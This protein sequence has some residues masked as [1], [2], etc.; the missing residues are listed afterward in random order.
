MKLSNY[1]VYE[2]S[3]S[4]AQKSKKIVDTIISRL[5]K[6]LEKK[7]FVI[8]IG[9][10]VNLMNRVSPRNIKFIATARPESAGRYLSYAIFDW[11]NN[12][13]TFDINSKTVDYLR[14]FAKEHK[15]NQFFD[16]KKNQFYKEL[17]EL[18]SH[19]MAHVLQLSKGSLDAFIDKSDEELGSYLSRKWEIDAFSL[20]AALEI[21][22]GDRSKTWDVY[23]SFK[24][25]GEITDKVYNRFKKK[26]YR[27]IKDLQKMGMTK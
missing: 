25:S 21:I 4:A 6:G 16:A 3:A 8:S 24:A 9:D 20:Q 23:T 7:S 14:R 27:N 18:M 26:V 2:S 19:E 15:K 10:L 11:D 13:I 22:N 12:E 5:W 1:I 17:L